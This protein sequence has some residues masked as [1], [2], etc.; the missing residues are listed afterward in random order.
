MMP[1]PPIAISG[2]VIASSP[3]ST[4]KSGGHGAAHVAHLRDVAGGFLDADD[5]RD[6]GEPRQRRRFDVHAG[7]AL[8]V[9]DE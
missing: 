8:D 1:R 5:V 4:M 9:V 3:D 6:L 7:P 2:S